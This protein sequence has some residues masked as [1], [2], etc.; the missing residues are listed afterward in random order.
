MKRHSV[1][2]GGFLVLNGPLELST[3][4][5][6]LNYTEMCTLGHFPGL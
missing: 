6:Q 3:I 4:G 2:K 5:K 1:P